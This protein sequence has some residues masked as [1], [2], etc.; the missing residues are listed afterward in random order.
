MI[1]NG[2]QSILLLGA[3]SIVG[4][5]LYL[6]YKDKLIPVCNT[7]N[8][9]SKC[10]SWGRANLENESEMEDVIARINPEILIHCGG[11]C[12]VDK[13]EKNRRWANEINVESIRILLRLLPKKTRLVYCSSDHVFSGDGSYSETSHPCPITVYGQTRVDAE[14]LIG[15]GWQNS[16]IIRYGLPI[17]PSLD[18]KTGHLDWLIYRSSKNLPMTIISDEYRSAVLADALSE[19]IMELALSNL[20][21]LRHIPISRIV[22]RKELADHLITK[23]KINSNYKTFSRND[24]ENKHI[25]K[26]KLVSNYN[27]NLAMPLPSVMDS[28]ST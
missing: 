20:T 15:H 5:N 14:A 16:I 4:W 21:G 11:I 9:N 18:G 3:T 12:D 19:R 23:Y 26:I 6:Q 8:T 28:K 22:S 10:A 27:D 25:G 7:H 13:C 2:N 24:L 1:N 17:G